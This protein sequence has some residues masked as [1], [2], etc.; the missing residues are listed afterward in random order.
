MKPA[1]NS[2]GQDSGLPRESD[3]D[4]ASGEP[5]H[6]WVARTL[7]ARIANGA[8][9]VGTPIPAEDR[10]GSEF[11]V[12]RA[13]IRHALRQLQQDR[14][15]ESRKGSGSVVLPPSAANTEMLHATSID[16][17]LAFSQGRRFHFETMRMGSIDDKLAV[18]AGVPAG[19]EWLTLTGVGRSEGLELP[20]CW[21]KYYI[22]KDF[23]TIGELLQ[24]PVVS[25]VFPLIE[26]RFGV[27]VVEVNQE[28]SAA[29]M[30]E[31]QASMLDV[32]PGTGAIDVRRIY[33]TSTGSVALITVATYPAHR[34][35]HS[36]RLHRLN[37]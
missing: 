4:V 2:H 6:A 5:L 35:K 15:I 33:T 11:A 24:S 1:S 13:T 9:P 21:A 37:G 19:S 16:D 28:M 18:D 32:E 10:L 34:F 20:D 22:H 30:S 25:P 31:V 3:R 23:A 8:Y 14:L 12:S 36:I 29:Q 27:R 26:E 17:L 7:R